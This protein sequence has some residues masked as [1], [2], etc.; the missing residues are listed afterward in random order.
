MKAL[1]INAKGETAKKMTKLEGNSS[2]YG[3]IIYDV[4]KNRSPEFGTLT[5]YEVNEY[6]D[7]I[8]DHFQDNERS[9]KK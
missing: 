4:M 8:A 5:V 3:D 7:L 2:D 9:S 1:A 6:L